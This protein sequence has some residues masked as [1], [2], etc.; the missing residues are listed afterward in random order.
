MIYGAVIPKKQI[1]TAALPLWYYL[2]FWH[3]HRSDRL[4]SIKRNPSVHRLAC[5]LYECGLLKRQTA[6]VDC[7]SDCNAFN[8]F[9]YLAQV[10]SFWIA[11]HTVLIVEWGPGIEVLLIHPPGQSSVNHSCTSRRPWCMFILTSIVPWG[12]AFFKSLKIQPTRPCNLQLVDCFKVF[13]FPRSKV[14]QIIVH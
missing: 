4:Q 3:S 10:M 9:K 6:C 12:F 8:I 2:L 11:V 13:F 5:S 7:I 1:K 14:N